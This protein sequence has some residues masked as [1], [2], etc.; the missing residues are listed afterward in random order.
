FIERATGQSDSS[1]KHGLEAQTDRSRAVRCKNP[2][3]GG[4]VILVDTPGL[5][6]PQKTDIAVMIE[7]ADFL[8]KLCKQK[9]HLSAIVY[10]H[11]ISDKRMTAEDPLRNLKMLTS[12]C[13]QETLPRIALGTTMWNEI[14]PETG[15]R[16]EQ[17]LSRYW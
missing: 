6:N 9:V 16:Q 13:G 12:L 8:Q 7:I 11:R 4:S 14:R 5:D 10:L 2:R 1:I 17:A 3:D 15:V